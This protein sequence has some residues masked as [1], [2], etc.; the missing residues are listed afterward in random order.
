MRGFHAISTNK[1]KETDVMKNTRI[2]IYT[3]CLVALLLAAAVGV[4]FAEHDASFAELEDEVAASRSLHG[5]RGAAAQAL[6]ERVGVAGAFMVFSK[7]AMGLI[8]EGAS[9]LRLPSVPECVLALSST[10]NPLALGGTWTIDGDAVGQP[11]GLAAPLEIM[12]FPDGFYG[13]GID[14]ASFFQR[15]T[16]QRVRVRLE[17]TDSIPSF[18]TTLRSPRFADLVRVTSPRP[19][20]SGEIVADASKGLEVEWNVPRGPLGRQKMVVVLF[21]FSSESMV[22][23]LRCGFALGKGK[24]WVPAQLLTALRNRLGPGPAF[25][26]IHIRTGD[27]KIV[28]RQHAAYAVEVDNDDGMTFAEGADTFMTIE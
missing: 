1:L 2:Q 3:R 20:A 25:G 27:F 9:I 24:A 12:P 14:P 7:V 17:G 23:E 16:G 18:A 10:S 8:W 22:G 28:R 6:E 5:D 11:G 13:I 26:F 21:A 19:A 4:A 15:D